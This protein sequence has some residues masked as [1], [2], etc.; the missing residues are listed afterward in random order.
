M[1]NQSSP[2]VSTHSVGKTGEPPPERKKPHYAVRQDGNR[3][4]VWY[5][6]RLCRR[7]TNLYSARHFADG[8]Q[9]M[10]NDPTSNSED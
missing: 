7:F 3:F 10:M 4:A 9:R 1:A 5:G 6:D 8:A 2:Y